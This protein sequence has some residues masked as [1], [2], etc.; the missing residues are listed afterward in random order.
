MHGGLR[1]LGAALALGGFALANAA[2]AQ[3]APRLRIDS[4]QLAG[5]QLRI[6]AESELSGAARPERPG[7]SLAKERWL[8]FESQNVLPRAADGAPGLY[9][10]ASLLR[11]PVGGRD[12][13]LTLPGVEA[14]TGADGPAAQLGEDLSARLGIGY[15]VALGQRLGLTFMVGGQ[16]ARSNQA[17][18]AGEPA[19]SIQRDPAALGAFGGVELNY[20]VPD[21]SG[22][23]I[24]FI[25]RGETAWQPNTDDA[26]ARGDGNGLKPAVLGGIRVAF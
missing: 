4:L 1:G 20:A 17:G 5:A 6:P 13:A 21:T 3:E 19:D 23:R 24:E 8:V 7:A 10:G 16:V 2:A 18:L 11:T 12:P 14:A 15:G 26:M 25:L 9:L 22:G